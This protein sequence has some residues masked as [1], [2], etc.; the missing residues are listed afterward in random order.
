ME[1]HR[2]TIPVDDAALLD[3]TSVV[4]VLYDSADVIGNCLASLP[5]AVEVVIVDNAST[6]D[7]LAQARRTRPDAIAIRSERNVGFGGGCNLGWRA[8]TRPFVAFINPDVCIHGNALGLLLRRLAHEQHGMIGPALLDNSGR[9]RLCKGRPSPWLDFCGLLP[10]AG[11]WAPAGWDGKLAAADPVHA[12]GGIV[13]TVEGACF[14]VRRSDLGS[15]GGFDEDMF[16]Y[17]EEESLAL[18]L[19][20]LGG[21]A[22]YEPRACA[23]HIGGTSTKKVGSSAVS[24]LRRS[25]VIY[26]RKRDGDL[27]GRIIGLLLVCAVMVS[28]PAALINSTLHRDRP[29]RLG[30]VWALLTGLVSGVAADLDGDVS[31]GT[32]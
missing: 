21:T 5:A 19:A 32:V 18:R 7:G 27:R 29:N 13:S 28:L 22:V 9:P 24:H 30:H 1:Q 12:A 15:I 16:L 14:V 23:S 17:Y 8:A 20:Q 11:R 26:Y 4:A 10:S 2:L 3:Q 25:Q 31:Y 6:D